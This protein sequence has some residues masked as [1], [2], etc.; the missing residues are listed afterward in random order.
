VSDHISFLAT[1]HFLP[2]KKSATLTVL[3]ANTEPRQ[4][5]AKFEATTVSAVNAQP[6]ATFA[7]DS[8]FTVSGTP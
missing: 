8:P 5:G 3:V 1:D 4:V 2:G 7:G 6:T